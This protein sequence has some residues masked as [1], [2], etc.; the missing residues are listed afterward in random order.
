MDNVHHKVFQEPDLNICHDR[1][2]IQSGSELTGCWV[3]A[4][5]CSMWCI[6][7]KI[8]KETLC[9]VKDELLISLVSNRTHAV[10]ALLFVLFTGKSTQRGGPS[11]LLL[12]WR[13]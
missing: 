5:P 4:S 13:Y 1:F 9:R 8:Q 12:H 2:I 11:A 7:N 3:L 10:P 6:F